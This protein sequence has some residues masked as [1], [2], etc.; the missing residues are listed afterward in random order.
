MQNFSLI[1]MQ[2]SPG[3]FA[4]WLGLFAI[5]LLFIAP[6]IS[7]SLAVSPA[8]HS[9]MMPGMAMAEMPHEAGMATHAMSAEHQAV[10]AD[11]SA[12]IVGKIQDKPLH[13]KSTGHTDTARSPP[14]SLMDDSACGYCL[15]LAHSPLDLT[16]LPP[17]WSSLQAAR[18]PE[19]PL[20]TP[21]VAR[22]VPR[23]FHPRA[24]PRR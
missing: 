7:K 1:K 8:W 18:L 21:V 14:L 9:M 17:L 23:F 11:P 19:L 15:L 13:S 3:G 22:F 5:I 20:F 24:P 6:M 16:R 12:T 10:M 2:R 4:A